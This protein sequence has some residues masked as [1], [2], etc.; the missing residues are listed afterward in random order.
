MNV[1][2]PEIRMSTGREFLYALMYGCVDEHYQ[3]TNQLHRAK[4]ILDEL[5]IHHLINKTRAFDWNWRFINVSTNSQYLSPS[6][7]INPVHT[8]P[9]Y[10]FNVQF[11]IILPYKPRSCNASCSWRFPHQNPVWRTL[12]PDTCHMPDPSHTPWFARPCSIWWELKTLQVLSMQF[13]SCLLL[14][15]H[16]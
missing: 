10:C 13:Y 3:V 7:K 16:S 5:T 11:N 6:S 12:L 2:S 9:F 4:V 8:L 1:H 14:L 15:L